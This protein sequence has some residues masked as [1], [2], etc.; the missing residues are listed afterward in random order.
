MCDETLE[1]VAEN[2]NPFHLKE[3][4]LDGCERITDQGLIKL[5]KPRSKPFAIPDLMNFTGNSVLNKR[6][7]EIAGSADDCRRLLANISLCGSRALEVISLAECRHITDAGVTK[8]VK[9][10]LLRKLCF[11]GCAA[12]KDEGIIG[13]AKD[14]TYL[15]EIDVGSTNITGES[16]RELTIFCLNLKKVNITGCKKL[17]A[18]DDLILKQNNINV[19][20]GEDVFRFHLIPEYNS[21]LPKITTSVLKTRSTL[22]LH[23]VYK[24]LLKKLEEANFEDENDTPIEQSVIIVCNGEVLSSSLQLKKVKE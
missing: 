23:K 17:N 21:D 16:L 15:E 3:L 4:Y 2:A 13:L 1:I 6:L 19:E 11:L 24:Y 22:S 7:Q 9:C 18:S 20:S 12:L 8:L 10:S 14:L 5:T